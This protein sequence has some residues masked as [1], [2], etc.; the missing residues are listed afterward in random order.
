M[1]ERFPS[2]FP[3]RDLTGIYGLQPHEITYLLDEA[4]QWITLNRASAVKHDDRLTGLT[5][6]NA[7]FE[8]RAPNFG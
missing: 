3:H 2:P 6:I 1:S 8:K 7:F 4:E 5:L